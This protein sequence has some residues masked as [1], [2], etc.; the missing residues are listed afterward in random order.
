MKKIIAFILSILTVLTFTACQEEPVEEVGGH[1][2]ING[3]RYT[4]DAVITFDN[5]KVPFELYRYFFLNNKDEY[6]SGDY[7][8][9]TIYPEYNDYV[10]DSTFNMLSELFAVKSIAIDAGVAA[11]R[12]EIKQILESMRADF[13]SDEEYYS[14]LKKGYLTEELF[15]DVFTLYQLYDKVYDHYYGD[16]G[17]E[18]MN[19]E[20]LLRF[21]DENFIHVKHI[22]VSYDTTEETYVTRA[23]VEEIR[24]KALAGESFD[25]LVNMY[26]DDADMPEYG[27]YYK[28]GD[29]PEAFELAVAE[30]ETDGISEIVETGYGFHIIQRLDSDISDLDYIEMLV[31]DELFSRM[32]EEKI[33]S[34]KV[35]YCD[36]YQEITAKNTY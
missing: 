28:A 15:Y 3:R 26:S 29:M 20:E 22:L 35:E 5:Q 9:F 8:V 32:I 2:L 33:Q 19:E 30:L 17:I 4:P 18:T 31:Y 14:E 34:Q 23:R 12:E 36:I 1:F 16:F 25:S 24:A 11:D 27:Y 21:A 13:E 7:S 6:S 10:K